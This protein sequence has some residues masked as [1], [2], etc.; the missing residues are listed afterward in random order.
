[1]MQTEVSVEACGLGSP[2]VCYALLASDEPLHV[3]YVGL[4][5]Q[6]LIVRLASH[7]A[8]K[9]ARYAAKQAWFG[10]VTARGAKVVMRVLSRHETRAEAGQA[11]NQ[12]WDFWNEYCSLLNPRPHA[13]GKRVGTPT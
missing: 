12:W 5:N 9:Q 2:F 10:E 3:R 7:L 11:E 13:K 1:M 8:G 4:T 6:P